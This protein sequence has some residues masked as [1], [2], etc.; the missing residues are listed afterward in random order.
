MRTSQTLAGNNPQM[1]HGST[2]IE[3]NLR[4]LG[5]NDN[6]RARNNLLLNGEGD[7]SHDSH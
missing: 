2:Q 1:I 4:G 5:T 7:A 3:A 6:A